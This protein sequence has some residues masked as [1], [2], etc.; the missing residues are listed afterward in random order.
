MKA[1]W[2]M[3]PL[4]LFVGISLGCGENNA[5]MGGG[6][7]TEDTNAAVAPASPDA[8]GTTPDNAAPGTTSPG[9]TGPGVVDPAMDPLTE[10][11]ETPAVEHEPA[12]APPE[13]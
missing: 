8:D 1:N 2:L 6:A 3:L 5:G 13:Q 7:E 10:V 9:A 12:T 11:D 4:A